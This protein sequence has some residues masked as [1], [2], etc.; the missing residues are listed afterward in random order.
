MEAMP[1]PSPALPS[2]PEDSRPQAARLPQSSCNAPATCSAAL[3]PPAKSTIPV[4]SQSHDILNQRLTLRRW[5]GG[6]PKSSKNRDNT[7]PPMVSESEWGLTPTARSRSALLL[8]Q[9]PGPGPGPGEC[10]PWFLGTELG[11]VGMVNTK[12]M[13]SKEGQVGDEQGLKNNQLGTM[14]TIWVTVH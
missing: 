12:T 3:S 7:F 10:V 14:F 1:A 9:P 4:S 5:V 11:T 6:G 13:P 2:T 8:V